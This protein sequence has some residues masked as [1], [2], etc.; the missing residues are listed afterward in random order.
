MASHKL[1]SQSAVLYV[2][3]WPKSKVKH[4]MNLINFIFNLCF[5]RCAK[6]IKKY[7]T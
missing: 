6:V 5:Y 7:S 1:P 2:N 3:E 4:K